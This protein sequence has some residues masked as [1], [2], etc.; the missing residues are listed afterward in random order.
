MRVASLAVA[1]GCWVWGALASAAVPASMPA[2]ARLEAGAT[3]DALQRTVRIRE[4]SLSPDGTRVAW[5]ES[6]PGTAEA[7]RLQVKELAHPERAP[8]RVTASKDGAPCAEGSLSW[9]PDGRWLAFLSTA[10][11]GPRPAA[12]RGGRVGGGRPRAEAHDAEGRAGGAE[13]VA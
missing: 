13:V 10:G 3:Y 2:S 4:V 12:L 9:S 11:G 1:V 6:V 8:V 5:V 7:A